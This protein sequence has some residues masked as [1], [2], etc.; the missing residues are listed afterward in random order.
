M[1][2]IEARVMKGSPLWW[3]CLMVPPPHP[4][5]AGGNGWVTHWTA[6]GMVNW[7]DSWPGNSENRSDGAVDGVGLGG[8]GH[9]E[10]DFVMVGVCHWATRLSMSWDMALNDNISHCASTPTKKWIKFMVPLPQHKTQ[11]PTVWACSNDTLKHMERLCADF[12]SINHF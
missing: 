5:A 3:P 6:M 12:R 8:W 2:A 11:V 4:S 1:A 10:V 7:D 9:P